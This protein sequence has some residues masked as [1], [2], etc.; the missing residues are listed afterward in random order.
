MSYPRGIHS[1]S[2][3]APSTINVIQNIVQLDGRTTIWVD[4][5]FT[6]SDLVG[7]LLTLSYIP[8][9]SSTILLSLNSG[10]QRIGEDF[11]VFNNKITFTFDV[12]PSDSIH[13][14]YIK[15]GAGVSTIVG[16]D[17]AVGTMVGYGALTA[18]PDGWLAMN[19]TTKVYDTV[20][21][22][23][24]GFLSSNLHLTTTGTTSV[25]G[26]GTY[27]TLKSITTS[28]YDGTQFVQGTTIIKT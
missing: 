16:A 22:L 6:G 12:P 2:P 7:R 26:T 13:V 28:Y 5:Q 24:F 4:E 27:Y 21:P 25:D 9:S 8:Y 1:H 19:G 11:T 3:E 10:V 23:L 14:R 18:P 20:Y 17:L 15:V